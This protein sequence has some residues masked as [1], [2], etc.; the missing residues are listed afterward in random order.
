MSQQT[1]EDP[2]T[3]NESEGLQVL[4]LWR[5]KVFKLCVQLR[6]K[7]IEVKREKDESLS[8]VRNQLFVVCRDVVMPYVLKP[9]YSVVLD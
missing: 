4:R 6:S 8:K 2:L 3:K 9:V 7:D 1:L 5:E